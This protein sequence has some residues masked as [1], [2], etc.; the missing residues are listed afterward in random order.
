MTRL[1]ITRRDVLILLGAGL[2]SAAPALS[3]PQ[4]TSARI[5]FLGLTN[6]TALHTRIEAFRAGLRDLGYEEGR[7][8]AIDFR[9]AEGRYERLPDLA[10]ELVVLGI[11][12]LVTHATPGAQ[13]AKQ[14]TATVPIVVATMSDALTAGVVA[15]IARPGGNL[16]GMTFFNREVMAKRLELLGE[17]APGLTAAAVLFNAD[18]P[19]P[20]R[21]QMVEGMEPTAAALK[22][23][24]RPF[25]I[26]QPAEF[27]T[28]IGAM[29]ESRMDAFV[30]MEDPLF[31]ANAKTLADLAVTHRLP[32]SG[33]GE[34][35]GAGG[36]L[37]Y[38]VD[39]LD[40]FRRAASHVDRILKGAKPGDLPMEQP[41][42]YV[43]AINLRTAK[44]LGVEAPPTLLAQVDEVIE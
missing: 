2:S 25:Q 4:S 34:F 40:M 37:G 3:K 15:S 42:K 9:F 43:F 26:R 44:A 30:V 1:L 22:I 31:I 18:T 23:G 7:N 28:V 8:L 6:P 24:L 41:A 33:F 21:R 17:A 29:A 38:G 32:T 20:I 35:A 10:K 5:G 16:T 13:A 39:F 12:V 19:A 36:L 11:D 27:E 14:A